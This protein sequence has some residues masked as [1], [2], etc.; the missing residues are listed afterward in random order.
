MLIVRGL[1]LCVFVALLSGGRA[2]AQDRGGFTALVDLGVGVQNDSGIQETQ[3]GL[4]G[5]NFGVGGFFT[6]D[7][8][9]MFRL[10]GT[11]VSYDFGAAGDYRQTSGVAGPT[12]Q[13]WLSNRVNLEAGAGWG[14]WSGADE[15]ETGPGLILGAGVTIFNRGKHNLQLGVQYSPAF[16]DPGTVH[17]MGFT[18]GYQFL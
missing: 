11:N 9:V 1:A 5:L 17:N 6:R 18:F 7:L 2:F 14:F 16:T 13:Y 12:V 3:A 10:T 8:A 15:D 4:A